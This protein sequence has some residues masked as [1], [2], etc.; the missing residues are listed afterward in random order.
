MSKKFNKPTKD[1]SQYIHQ[2]DK[3]KEE[4]Q[5]KVRYELTEKQKQ[6]IETINN[7][8]TNVV[9]VSGPAGSSKTFVS[10]LCGLQQLQSGSIREIIYSR[11]ILESSDSGSKIGY[12]P[13]TVSDKIDPY[14]Q[15][16]G[17]KLDE[18]LDTSIS[19]KLLEDGRVRFELVNFVRGASWNSTYLILDEAQNYTKAELI[20]L[21]TRLGHRCKAIVLADPMQSDLLNGK[22]GGFAD[23]FGKFSDAESKD[24]GIYTFQF[25]HE[26][27]VRSGL[28][29]FII[30]KLEKTSVEPM[31]TH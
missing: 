30:S 29:K 11:P 15:A 19:N 28:C 18:L 3:L 27:I 8:E 23:L 9:F 25:G 22:R 6:L 2:K 7:K 21:L 26:D 10:V 31:F 17:A 1:T 16:V 24:H 13:G 5:I 4:F 20:T 12:L 14:A